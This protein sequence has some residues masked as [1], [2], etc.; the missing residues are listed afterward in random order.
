MPWDYTYIGRSVDAYYENDYVLKT[1]AIENVNAANGFDYTIQPVSLRVVQRRLV[2]SRLM[3]IA[4]SQ[5]PSYEEYEQQKLLK[6]KLGIP[7]CDGLGSSFFDY[8]VARG[9]ASDQERFESM[10]R[11]L[12]VHVSRQK[13][14]AVAYE[15]SGVPQIEGSDPVVELLR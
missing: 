12:D 14:A 5:Q 3:K 7:S 2:P 10:N 9:K 6:A 15:Q 4:S 8:A 13:Y 1:R 11:Q